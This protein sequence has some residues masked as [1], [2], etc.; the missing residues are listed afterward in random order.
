[1]QE[2]FKI[3]K[4]VAVHGL[5]G[6]LILTHALG[7]KSALKGLKKIF[8][9]Q[10]KGSFLPYF[11]EAATPRSEDETLLKLEDINTPE[12][13]KKLF[14]RDVWLHEKDFKKFSGKQTPI[15]LLG[16]EILL[17][18]NSLGKIIEVIEQPHQVLCTIMLG[19]KEAYIPL[20]EESLLRIDHNNK[21]IFVQLPEGLLDIY[22]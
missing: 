1:M 14:P 2:Y 22:R 4:L 18:E 11:I 3:G 5:K 10:H 17:D 12:A 9:E 13:A 8:I 7:K 20:H 21:K 6:H 19:D 15:G 16:Y